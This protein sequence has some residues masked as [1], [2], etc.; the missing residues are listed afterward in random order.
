[1]NIFLILNAFGHVP[2]QKNI[3]KLLDSNPITLGYLYII[4]VYFWKFPS[5]KI[6]ATWDRFLHVSTGE[7]G[8]IKSWKGTG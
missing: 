4:T 8:V 3:Q 7:I 1:M 2:N 5:D 6:S